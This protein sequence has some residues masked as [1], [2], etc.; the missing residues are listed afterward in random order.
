MASIKRHGAN[1]RRAQCVEYGGL[2]YS[3]GITSQNT[4]GD[5][6]EQTEDVLRV[7]DNLLARRGIDK[8]RVLSATVT[9][10]DMADYGAFNAVWDAWV[11][12]GFEPARSV[13]QGAL[14]VPEYKVKIS[15]IAAL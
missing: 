10:A 8:G 1:G 14:A 7:I 9:L 5:I 11:V 3:S 4:E 2:L 13:T 6:T 12:D 15:V